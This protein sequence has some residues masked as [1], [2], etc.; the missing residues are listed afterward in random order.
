[1]ACAAH[2]CFANLDFRLLAKPV[3]WANLADIF[4]AK[5]VGT[6]VCVLLGHCLQHGLK[7]MDVF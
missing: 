4:C 5:S 7:G 3:A 6:S 1:M 2:F